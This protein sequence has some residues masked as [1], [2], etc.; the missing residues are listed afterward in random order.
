MSNITNN[1]NN[2]IDADLVNN[3]IPFK[4]VNF[5]VNV[6][7][8]YNPVRIHPEITE[9]GLIPLNRYNP[10]PSVYNCFSSDSEVTISTPYELPPNFIQTLNYVGY[11]KWNS[12]TRMFEQGNNIDANNYNVKV[13]PLYFDA[14]NGLPQKIRIQSNSNKRFKLTNDNEDGSLEVEEDNQVQ[15]RLMVKFNTDSRSITEYPYFEIEGVPPTVLNAI[16]SNGYYKFNGDNLVQGTS[17]DYNIYVNTPVVNNYTYSTI[18]SNGSYV[19]PSGY[20]GLNGIDVNVPTTTQSIK[21]TGYSFKTMGPKYFND[22]NGPYHDGSSYLTIP[23]ESKTST[24]NYLCVFQI[25]CNANSTFINT[26]RYGITCFRYDGYNGSEVRITTDFSNS[27]N[28]GHSWYHYT[29]YHGSSAISS[30]YSYF[31]FHNTNGYVGN[32]QQK[33]VAV[34]AISDT[35]LSNDNI[36]IFNGQ[37]YK[38]SSGTTIGGQTYIRDEYMNGLPKDFFVRLPNDNLIEK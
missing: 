33:V 23:L 8:Q 12:T 31:I 25:L 16:V 11:W 30:S 29:F 5:N 10:N 19:I 28:N 17:Q 26:Y 36:I 32:E 1:G 2:S 24:Y 34:G 37:T 6:E 9:R 15:N 13:E 14:D 21:L 27:T 7:S 18:T 4:K 20:T 22:I 38:N 3:G 35:S